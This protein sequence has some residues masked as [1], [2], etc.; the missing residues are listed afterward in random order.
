MFSSSLLRLAL[1]LHMTGRTLKKVLSE[2][3]VLLGALSLQVHSSD[4]H[5]YKNAETV[6]EYSGVAWCRS[7]A[8]SKSQGRRTLV[9]P[10][11]EVLLQRVA[12]TP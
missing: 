12:G 2:F 11:F 1:L 5:E 9:D 3:F 8:A 6:E 10:A 7:P 4:L